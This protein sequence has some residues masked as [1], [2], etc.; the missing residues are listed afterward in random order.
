MLGIGEFAR[1]GQVSPRTLRH[2]G[3]LG[4]LVPAHVDDASGYRFYAIDQLAQLQ[5]VVA[6]RNLG[7]RLDEIRSLV[8][9]GV[10]EEHLR[11]LLRS[12]RAEIADAISQEQ[13]RLRQIEARLDASE[14]GA[15]ME[16][17]DVVLKRSGPHRVA[18]TTA[19]APGHGY[20][21]IGPVFR[22]HLPILADE[23]LAQRLRLGVCVVW[24]EEAARD[25]LLVHLGWDVE[26]QPVTETDAVRVED[27]HV[28]EVASTIH[29]GS[30]E[31]VT[32][33]FESMIRWIEA[34]GHHV[35]GPSRELYW[36]LDPD[37]SRQI[38]ELQIPV[39]R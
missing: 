10:P 26:D 4:I 35:V 15:G 29:H 23:L 16:Q 12:R 37:E 28:V 22:A 33:R 8:A 25:E 24:Y 38:T 2:Y 21:N 3:E 39:A 36:R 9:D 20:E 17:L 7:L 19:T 11:G 30:M 14:G 34:T 27:L 1:L 13:V 6:L 32:T 18:A 31:G 5:R